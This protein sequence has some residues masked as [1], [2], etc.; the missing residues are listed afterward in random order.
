MKKD[1]IICFMLVLACC[2]CSDWLD[3]RPRTEM[4][5]E[6]MYASEDGFKNVLTGAYIRM[7]SEDLYGKNMSVYFTELLA[8]HWQTSSS[9]KTNDC[10]RKFDFEEEGV[11]EVIES[12][13]LQYYKT[14]AGLNNLLAQLKGKESM[15]SNGNYEL[16][17]GEALGLRGFLHFDLLR[18][19]GPVP[20]DV[21]KGEL[22]IPYL[23]EMTKDPNKAL[24]LTYEKVLEFIM[25]DLDEAEEYL[26]NDPIIFLKPSVLNIP[27]NQVVAGNYKRPEDVW[28]YYR[29]NRFNYYAVLATKARYYLWIGDKEKA[30]TYA[31]E[32]IKATNPEDEQSKFTL[33]DNAN[34]R[35]MT[36][37]QIF[38]VHN[39]RLEDIMKPLF[40][41]FGGLTQQMKQIEKAYEKDLHP[42]DIR[43]DKKAYWE[44][45]TS[46][47]SSD[48]Q[49]MFKK[50]WVDETTSTQ[51]VPIIRLSEMYM[52]VMECASLSE[53]SEKFKT[54]RISRN[55]DSSVDNELVDER[56]V[57][58]RLEKEYRK[59]FYGEGQMF[60]F[61]KRRGVDTYTWPSNFTVVKDKYRVPKPDS[62]IKFE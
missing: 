52:I 56:S 5:E 49:N 55:M 59:E 41:N 40:I 37:E 38:A 47:V 44:E 30:R 16:I 34:D 10:I 35:I 31:N 25:A 43:W 54:F 6:D 29:Q 18:L 3:V 58:E 24:P 20:Q 48:A 2:S 13:W 51:Y 4:K 22:T 17:Y 36:C 33:A 61:Y 46:S 28:Q 57:L 42:N 53:A 27:P 60:F 32:V 8:Q 45:R 12:M 21:D 1:Y 14:I 50:Y 9:N 15:F 62:Q 26:K 19:W 39:S 23:K 11:K 7:A